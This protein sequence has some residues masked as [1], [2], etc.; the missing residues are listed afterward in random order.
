[1]FFPLICKEWNEKHFCIASPV[2][3]GAGII[4][5]LSSE[6]WQRAP[7]DIR[8][9]AAREKLR[10]WRILNFFFLYFNRI[11]KVQKLMPW[12]LWDREDGGLHS[13]AEGTK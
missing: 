7:D 13:I 11:L 8:A 10:G 9:G 3:D 1:M 5:Y 12:K 4:E 6:P 2:F